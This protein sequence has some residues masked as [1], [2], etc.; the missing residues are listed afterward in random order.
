[1]ASVVQYDDAA[2]GG[3]IRAEAIEVAVPVHPPAPPEATAKALDILHGTNGNFIVAVLSFVIALVVAIV[4]AFQATMTD[5]GRKL[6]VVSL[7]W[8]VAQTFTL[9]KTIRDRFLAELLLPRLGY[10]ATVVEGTKAWLL[11]AVL[12]FVASCVFVI[13][14]LKAHVEAVEEGGA[15]WTGGGGLAVLGAAF[16][17]V[18]SVYLCKAV[19]DRADAALFT[20]LDLPDKFDKIIAVCSG[21]KANMAVVVVGVVGSLA[22]TLGGAWSM[23]ADVVSIERKGFILVAVLF[24]CASSFHVAKLIRDDKDEKLKA[25]HHCM[26]RLLVWGAFVIAL[27]LAFIGVQVMTIPAPEKAYI[28]VGQ[29]AILS[30][31]LS[32]AKMIRDGQEVRKLTQAGAPAENNTS[33]GAGSCAWC[34]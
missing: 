4:G 2:G 5:A 14:S 27:G 20:A 3:G 7:I 15:S 10:L 29:L 25:Q 31:N 16:S 33:C 11:Q 24:M 22:A 28:Q 26:F 30:C 32:F 8:M 9:A 6:F 34:G 21:T 18:A 19:R 17:L 1:M 23:P 12:L 13:H